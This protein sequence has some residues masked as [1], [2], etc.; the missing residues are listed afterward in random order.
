MKET[1]ILMGMP[2]TV[3]VADAGVTAASLEVVF[4]YFRYVDGKFSTYQDNSEISLINQGALPVEQAS[5]D[6]RTIFALAEQTKQATNGY[7]DIRRNGIYDP[8]GVVKGWAI[9]HA[10]GMLRQAGFKNYYVD[11][12]G[13]IQA[14]GKN[15]HGQDW[16]VGIRN[17]FNMQEIV[18]VLHVSECGVATSGTYVRGQHIYSPKNDAESLKEIVSLTVVA[19]DIYDADRFATAAFAMGTTGILFIEQ[20]AGCEGYMI[21]AQGRATFT[22]GFARYIYHD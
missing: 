2:V 22:S 14:A 8:S 16:R 10:A 3:E 7:F 11:A 19:P 12:G 18:K 9:A 20:L 17:P 13:D 15:S 6:M 1:R 4:G 21:N 5:M